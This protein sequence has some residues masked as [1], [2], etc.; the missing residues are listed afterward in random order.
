MPSITPDTNIPGFGLPSS[1][2]SAQPVILIGSTGAQIS[3]AAAVP[4]TI[5]S[6][7]V[8]SGGIA[9]GAVASGAIASGAIASGAVASGAIAAGAIAAGAVAAVGNTSVAAYA[10]NLVIKGSAGRLWGLTGYNSKGSAQFIQLHDAASQ[11]ADTAV[12]K[13]ILTVAASSN[14]S[15]D[16]GIYGK[17][18]ATGIVVT[19]S[20]TG[21]TLTVGSADCWFEGRST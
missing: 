2:T 5:A 8:A 15:I 13:V 16:F 19:N 18:F 20:S 9:S 6:G 14:F 17:N 3:G 11:P 4:V 10:A 7:G 12:P 1:G 21:P